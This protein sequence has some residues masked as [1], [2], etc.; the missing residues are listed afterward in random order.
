M[1]RSAS[2]FCNRAGLLGW[3]QRTLPSSSSPARLAILQS[4]PRNRHSDVASEQPT[5]TCPHCGN[6]HHL[7]EIVRLDNDHLQC[8]KWKQPFRS[9]IRVIRLIGCIEVPEKHENCGG[10][11]RKKS[12]VIVSATEL[13][14]AY[15]SKC[16]A[17]VKFDGPHLRA[18]DI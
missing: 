1:R 7:G 18:H 16:F 11:F 13:L 15:C 6:E 3:Q 5:W 12:L 14:T 2:H 8:Q 10:R 4:M 9:I 17:R